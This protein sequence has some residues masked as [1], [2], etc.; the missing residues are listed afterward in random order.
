MS[1]IYPFCPKCE[2]L[3]NIEFNNSLYLDCYCDK[4][5]NHKGEKIFFPT[6][7]KFYLKENNVRCSKCN[8]NLL[9]KYIFEVESKN[10]KEQKGDKIFCSNCFQQIYESIKVDDF[11]LNIKSNK[12]KFHD[13]DLNQY[14]IDCKKHICIFCSIED[15]MEIHKDH[16]IKN[17]EYLIPSPKEIDNLKQRIKQKSKVYK[18]LKN[19]INIWKNKIMTK[20]EQLIENL[21]KEMLILDKIVLNFNNKFMNYTYYNDFIHLNS[22]VKNINNEYLIKFNNNPDFREQSLNLIDLF[23]PKKPKTKILNANITNNYSLQGINPEKIN[24]QFYF[25]KS[26]SS[27]INYNKYNNE[28]TYYCQLNDFKEEIYTISLSLDRQIIYACLNDKKVVKLFFNFQEM[29]F[30]KLN[31]EI[32]D[33]ENRYS[34]FNK[35]IQLTKKYLAT[36]DNNYIKIWKNNNKEQLETEI[37]IFIGSKTSDLLLVNDEYFISSQPDKK[38]IIIININTFEI[39]KTIS[40]VDCIDSQNSL[41]SLQNFVIINCVKDIQLLFK[42]TKEIIQNIQNFENDSWNKE[43]FVY[44]NRLYILQEFQEYKNYKYSSTIKISIFEFFE[45]LLENIREYQKFQIIDDNNLKFIVMND[46]QILLLGKYK[47]ILK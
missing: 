47:Y 34:H 19:K 27:I 40:N 23:Y 3:L 28:F 43:L 36:A 41:L 10:D 13:S 44:N 26:K 17:L 30:P 1:I 32:I 33:N 45:G 25:D 31:Q 20:T 8:N 15:K 6:F 2:G 42:E 35:C 29:Q 46:E 4:C 21:E 38:T 9:N 11:N 18:E 24:N 12:C 7:E 37:K 16:N 14:C 5:E 39:S 22:F